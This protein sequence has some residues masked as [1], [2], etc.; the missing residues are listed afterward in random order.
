M[1]LFRPIKLYTTKLGWSIVYIER[2]H[3]AISRKIVFLSLKI[4]FVLASHADPDVMSH[5]IWVFSVCHSVRFGVSGPQVV[6]LKRMISALQSKED[7][8]DQESINHVQHL[9][10]DTTLEIDIN[11]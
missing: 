6:I 10:Q 2:T 7:D 1:I 8:K 3:V 5:F 9:T 4:E 11:T